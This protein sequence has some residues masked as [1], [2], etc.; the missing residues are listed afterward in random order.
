MEKWIAIQ[1]FLARTAQRRYREAAEEFDSVVFGSIVC[2]LFKLPPDLPR[3]MS[4]FSSSGYHV[5]VVLLA[6]L[7]LAA[8]MLRWVF[9]A[10]NVRR[11]K[12]G[13]IGTI[14]CCLTDVTRVSVAYLVFHHVSKT[15]LSQ[16]YV[17]STDQRAFIVQC[18]RSP[19][20]LQSS[21]SRMCLALTVTAGQYML[22]FTD[23]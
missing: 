15:W 7:S 4:I 19:L 16:P 12:L 23:P 1:I 8:G 5:I 22:R 3:F 17:Y 18:K 21:V 10:L 20:A 9:P 2:V 11:V 13:F 14:G 6:L